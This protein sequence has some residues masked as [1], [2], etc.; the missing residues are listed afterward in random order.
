MK[1]KKNIYIVFIAIA[2]YFVLSLCYKKFILKDEFEYIYILNKNVYRGDLVLEEDLIKVKISGDYE[3]KYVSEYSSDKYYTDDYFK[4]CILL[5]EMLMLDEEYI[6]S[7]ANSEIISIK[8]N[9][10][11]YAASYQIG[12]GSIVNIFYSARFSDVSDIVSTA[13]K[14]TVNSNSQGNGH[15]TVR[16]LEKV[17]I[18]NCYDKYGKIV[19]TNAAI[20]TIL[21][22]VSKDESIKIN[23][24]KNCGKF[25]VSIIK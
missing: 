14:L 2:I 6:K 21:L 11:E 17:K 19:T 13:D 9:L 20:E 24:L 5:D 3:Y 7:N 4:G 8:L 23:N 18:I 25:S 12:K 22:E 1:F 16:L 15:V 10:A